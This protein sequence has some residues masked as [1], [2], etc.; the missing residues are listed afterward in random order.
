MAHGSAR[1]AVRRLCETR[2]QRFARTLATPATPMVLGSPRTHPRSRTRGRTI[3]PQPSR[4]SPP[5]PRSSVT[6][7]G[8]IYPNA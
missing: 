6:R 7:T 2:K 3:L 5:A 4:L 1:F 8:D